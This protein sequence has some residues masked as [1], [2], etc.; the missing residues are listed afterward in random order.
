MPFEVCGFG[1][2]NIGHHRCIVGSDI[3][4]YKEIEI[5]YRLYRLSRIRHRGQYICPCHDPALYWVGNSGNSCKADSLHQFRFRKGMGSNGYRAFCGRRERFARDSFQASFCRQIYPALSSPCPKDG[6][7]YGQASFTLGVVA[8]PCRESPRMYTYG[9][10]VPADFPCSLNNKIDGQFGFLR[11]PL[12]RVFTDSFPQFI[13]ASS[14]SV[15]VIPVIHS[16][17]DYYVNPGKHEGH[18]SARFDRKPVGRLSGSC[19]EPGI[20]NDD[21]CVIPQR[22]GEV[23]HLGVVHVLSKVRAEKDDYPAVYEVDPFR[24]TDVIPVG[25]FKG[26]N[27][28]APALTEGREGVVGTAQCPPERHQV[29]RYPAVH[30]KRQR[31]GPVTVFD[32]GNLFCYIVQGFAPGRAFVFAFPSCSGSDQGIFEPVLI[33]QLAYTGIAPCTEFPL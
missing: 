3:N 23:L 30:Q 28:C 8:V 21:P 19:G 10:R 13:E 27:P 6:G 29:A 31:L 32:C 4:R 14:V 18:V 12:R 26:N 15:D 2:N 9:W 11:C 1:Q 22:L 17:I 24:G 20:N 7:E 5:L 16:F 33:I 25:E